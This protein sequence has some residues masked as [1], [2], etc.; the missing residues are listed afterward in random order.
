MA[1]ILTTRALT[2][3]VVC[4]R[5]LT[6]AIFTLGHS[7]ERNLD[8]PSPLLNCFSMLWAAMSVK[9]SNRRHWAMHPDN[10][11]NPLSAQTL[12]DQ[13]NSINGA[14]ESQKDRDRI[15]GGQIRDHEAEAMSK[16]LH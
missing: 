11:R 13:G 15:E 7:S 6:A 2:V 10:S 8:D 14:I 1:P 9:G 5:V 12:V 4:S 16:E 3:T